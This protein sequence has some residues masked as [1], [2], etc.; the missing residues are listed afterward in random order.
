MDLHLVLSFLSLPHI[1]GDKALP[2]PVPRFTQC[3]GRMIWDCAAGMQCASPSRAVTQR[4]GLGLL[5][6]EPPSASV[7]L[8]RNATWE[9]VL[10]VFTCHSGRILLS[11]PH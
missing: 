3:E 8:T 9:Q 10:F 5:T 11:S 6:E 2:L 1:L 7:S 4:R